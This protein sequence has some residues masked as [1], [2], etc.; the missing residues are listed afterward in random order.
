MLWKVTF[1]RQARTYLKTTR[2]SPELQREPSSLPA[3]AWLTFQKILAPYTRDI[4]LK[5]TFKKYWFPKLA[6]FFVMENDFPKNVAPYTGLFV[7][8][9]TF[10]NIG[11]LYWGCFPKNIWRWLSKIIGHYAGDIFVWK[12]TFQKIL[13]PYN[14]NFIL[15]TCSIYL[16]VGKKCLSQKL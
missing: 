12:A 15:Y 13:S 1:L 7:W 3:W 5:V 9:L 2:R 14:N 16:R 8:K 4:I 11:L 6:L 10:Q